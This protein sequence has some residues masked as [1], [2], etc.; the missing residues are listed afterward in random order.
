LGVNFCRSI[1]I[2]VQQLSLAVS[3]LP[4]LKSASGRQKSSDNIP[5]PLWTH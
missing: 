1:Q 4:C 3:L 2:T 5:V